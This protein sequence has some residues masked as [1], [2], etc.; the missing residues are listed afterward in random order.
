M[1]KVILLS[2]FFISTVFL[3]SQDKYPKK[4]FIAPVDFKMLLSGN[5][6]ELRGNH[7]H[8][9]IDIKTGG[10]SGKKI[11]A[12]ADGYISRIKVS[13]FGFGK[14]IYIRHGNGY[15]SVYGHL[16][17]FNEKL[18]KWVKEQ[19]YSKESFAVDLYPRVNQFMVSQ[20]EVIALSGNSG[21]SAGPHLHF[22]IRDTR[23]EKPINPLLFGFEIKDYIRPKIKGLKI[24]PLTKGS[25]VNGKEVP[26]EFKPEGWGMVYRL[27]RKE[28][29]VVSGE[30]G[31]AIKAY[32]LMNDSHNNVGLY[33]VELLIDS[34]LVFKHEIERFAFS[35]TRYIN[36]YIDYAHYVDHG[37]RYQR[38]FVDEGNKLST[39]K[40]V[41][42]NG[43][44]LF[45]DDKIHT[46]IYEI[47]DAYGNTSRLTCKLQSRPMSGDLVEEEKGGQWFAWDKENHFENEEI[48]LKFKPG[49]FYESFNFEYS[50][51][52]GGEDLYSNIHC[53]HREQV[54][55]HK[56]YRMRIKTNGLPKELASK[57]LIVDLT[58]ETPVAVG[59]SYSD[60]FVKADHRGF[61]K[62][63][64]TIDTI[65]PEIKALN[66]H[67]RKKIS[68][69][70]KISF[71][72]KDE[73]SGIDS[74]RGTL[75][76]QW[77]LMDYDP[78]NESLTYFVDHKMNNGKNTFKLE[79]VDGKNNKSEFKADVFF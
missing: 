44:V 23:S 8:S 15:T 30:I 26:W 42:K 66:I 49:S 72:I 46:L 48:K 22:E 79:V 35:E 21:G 73:C 17:S 16:S 7:F 50:A 34:S 60:G 45:N 65:P 33:S 47:K 18:H 67:D 10:E 24:Y 31:F 55:V 32:D 2:V 57:A 36:S 25:T 6:G 40:N 52:E 53:V 68:G 61:G 63:A 43:K 29:V 51:E 38:G 54:P 9:G 3:Y 11:Y 14:A 28:P 20:G 78:K 56:P 27:K 76:G 5:F 12:I 69:Y 64:V 19:Q 39:I 74:Y 75:N 71:K 77:I 58:E 41:Y 62:F 13:P 1:R 59:G 4:D 37:E 70:K